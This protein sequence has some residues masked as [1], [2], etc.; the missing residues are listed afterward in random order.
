MSTW[1]YLWAA[2]TTAVGLL[3]A[4]LALATGGRARRMQ[5]VVECWG[6]APRRLLARRPFRASA[7]TL[8]HVVVGESDRALDRCRAHELVHVRQ[9]ERWGPLFIPAYLAAGLWARLRGRHPYHDNPF[10]I[11]ARKPGAQSPAGAPDQ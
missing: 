2:P 3:V 7:L 6:G 4:L 8:G 10:E 5:G 9:A 11:E 1:R